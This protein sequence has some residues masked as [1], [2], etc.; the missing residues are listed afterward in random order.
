MYPLL[1]LTEDDLKGIEKVEGIEQSLGSYTIDVLAE[2]DEQEVVLR[3]HQLPE[4][5]DINNIRLMKEGCRKPWECVME[6]AKLVNSHYPLA[7][8]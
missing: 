7:L 3:V 4:E 8:S 1:G 2:L 6:R 5:D